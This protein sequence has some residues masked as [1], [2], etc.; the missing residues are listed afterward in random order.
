VFGVGG[1]IRVLIHSLEYMDSLML[2]RTVRYRWGLP[3]PSAVELRRRRSEL[4]RVG[5]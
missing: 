5:W 4:G 3:E 1:L 2:C